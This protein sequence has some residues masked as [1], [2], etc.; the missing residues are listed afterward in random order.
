VHDA[1]LITAPISELDADIAAMRAYMEQASGVVLAG[2][3]LDT[4]A[5][6]VLY[7][8]RYADR[9]GAKMFAKVMDLL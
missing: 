8:D 4:E 2:F 6:T 1:V 5:Q 3:K 7:P 9:R